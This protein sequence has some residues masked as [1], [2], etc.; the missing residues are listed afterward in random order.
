MRRKF[1]LSIFAAV[2]VF[3]A[4][5]PVEPVKMSVELRADSVKVMGQA[6]GILSDIEILKEKAV[7]SAK[8]EADAL[9][10]TDFFYEE[11][12][13]SLD[14][15]V[16]GFPA[17]YVNLRLKTQEYSNIMSF[18]L[19][20]P[21]EKNDFTLLNLPPLNVKTGKGVYFSAKTQY[22]IHAGYDYYRRYRNG[23]EYGFNVSLGG[24]TKY[25][26]IAGD[27]GLIFSLDEND[28]SGFENFAFFG[29]RA[30]PTEFFQI[31]PGISYG[32]GFSDE[33]FSLGGTFVKLLFGKNK[34]WFEIGHRWHFVYYN[35]HQMMF[36]F[37]YAPSKK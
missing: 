31:I 26:L 11:D 7:A 35:T 12:G 13:D 27:I 5:K 34:A 2:S 24:F 18:N 23:K 6:R 9:I 16:T 14:V 33:Y 25:F 4:E 36:G 15:T 21:N 19:E 22:L 20:L 29:F 17:R 30:Q 28:F 3:A 8:G 37:T 1:F 10:E 32:L